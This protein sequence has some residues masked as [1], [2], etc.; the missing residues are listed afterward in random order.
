MPGPGGVA[1]PVTSVDGYDLATQVCFQPL[2][3]NVAGSAIPEGAAKAMAD[4]QSEYIAAT[5]AVGSAGQNPNFVGN[6]LELGYPYYPNFRTA[7]SYQLNI[8]IQ[9]QIGK[10]VLTVDYLRN[11]EVHFQLGID[12][13]HAGDSRY[14]NLAAANNA[15]ASTL[16]DCGVNTIDAAIAACPGLYGPG[17]G[18]ASIN[19]FAN[20]GLDSGEAYYGGYSAQ[21]FGLT[22]NTGA[23]F[24]GINP[25]MGSLYMNYPMG[26]SVYSGLQSEYKTQIANP[27]RGVRN[28]DLRVNYTYSRFVS[29]AGAD[30]HFTINAFDFR[31]PTAYM[32]PTSQDRTH[33]FKFGGTFDFLRHGP[34]LGLIGG[35]ASPQPSSL[36][37]PTQGTIGEIF[38][39]DITGDGTTGDLLNSAATG[40]GHPG[41]F[42]RSVSRGGLGNYI[43]SFNATYGNGQTITPAGQA[44]VNAGL[45]TQSQLVSLGAVIPTIQAPPQNNAGNGYYKDIDMVFRWPFKIRERFTVEPSVSF[46]N[47]FNFVNYGAL[48]LLNGGDGSINNTTSG[49]NAA[50]N[51]VRVG[52]GTGVFA[53]GAPREAEYGLRINF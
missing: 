17:G 15:I 50:T 25:N 20:E 37:L 21:Y 12:V 36:A 2:G 24:G 51:T 28:F 43:Q 33:Q 16:S 14:L 45:F 29:D 1:N 32:G 41:T 4:L 39:S 46:F 53:V 13:N 31:N 8:G 5:A 19:D 7:R 42:M 6:T 48:S 26:R 47:V 30:Q 9:R 23:A 38:R 11:I 3:P 52:R 35:F 40:I 34:Q 49:V 10:G 18:G 22:P 27:F 44:L